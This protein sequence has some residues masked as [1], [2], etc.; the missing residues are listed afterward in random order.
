MAAEWTLGH[1]ASANLIAR[2]VGFVVF[3][4]NLAAL[5]PGRRRR[6]SV[7]AAARILGRALV[8]TVTKMG[9]A[10]RE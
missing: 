5:G 3:L 7:I 10:A 4:V 2:T 9:L 8:E 1:A 6:Q